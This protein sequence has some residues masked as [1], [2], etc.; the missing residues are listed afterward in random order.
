MAAVRPAGPPPMTR[1]SISGPLATMALASPGRSGHNGEAGP[2]FA[3]RR[4][5]GKK[6]LI[7]AGSGLLSRCRARH[8]DDVEG[9][10]GEGRDAANQQAENRADSPSNAPGATM[11]RPAVSAVLS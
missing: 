4:H 7:Q 1:Q 9:W 11:V 2:R 8:M 10:A 3:R 5:S 6:S